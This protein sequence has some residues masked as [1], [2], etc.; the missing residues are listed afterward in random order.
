VDARVKRLDPT[1]EHLGTAR[2]FRDV[3]YRETRVSQCTRGTA[4]GDQL[5]TEFR[6]AAP[7]ID[8]TRLVRDREKSALHG[9]RRRG[10][11]WGLL[12]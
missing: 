11:H 1:T 9:A 6:E 12:R 4:G 10:G 8:E 3:D 7:K 2:E 5:D